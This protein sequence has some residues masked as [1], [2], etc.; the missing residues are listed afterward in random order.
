[1]PFIEVEVA[2]PL[3]PLNVRLEYGAFCEW[4]NH[5]ALRDPSHL[6]LSPV[7]AQSTRD[8]GRIGRSPR[9]VTASERSV[10]SRVRHP[11]GSSSAGEAAESFAEDLPFQYHL[12][13]R[14]EE[15][16]LQESRRSCRSGG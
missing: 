13:E 2:C 9:F 3:S 16:L 7:T 8:L 5:L 15:K 12:E 1:M 14:R 11:A 10:T 4:L 6:S